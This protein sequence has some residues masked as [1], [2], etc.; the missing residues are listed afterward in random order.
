[1]N[2]LDEKSKQI[3]NTDGPWNQEITNVRLI[4]HMEPMD[5]Q[6]MI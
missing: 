2:V 6:M 3:I 5:L 1:M 4:L